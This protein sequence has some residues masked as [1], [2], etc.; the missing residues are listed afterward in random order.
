MYQ[1]TI[2]APTTHSPNG[3]T[4]TVPINSATEIEGITKTG[5]VRCIEL[6]STITWG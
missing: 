5:G 3:V 6:L 1:S 2:I 4:V